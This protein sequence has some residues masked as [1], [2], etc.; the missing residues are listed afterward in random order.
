MSEQHDACC[1]ENRD[2]THYA[3]RSAPSFCD[4]LHRERRGYSYFLAVAWAQRRRG[5]VHENLRP[6]AARSQLRAGAT[7]ELRPR[8]LTMPRE[9]S[10]AWIASLYTRQTHAE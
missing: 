8:G 4:D 2:E 6:F 10:S 1:V 3:S 9:D 7:S 5:V